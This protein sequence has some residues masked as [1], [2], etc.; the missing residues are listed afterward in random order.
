M[1][2]KSGI[3]A[4]ERKSETYLLLLFSLLLVVVVVVLAELPALEVEI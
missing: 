4:V 3:H 1:N 2:L